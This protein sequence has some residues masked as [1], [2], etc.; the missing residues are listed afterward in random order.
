MAAAA[1]MHVE[2]CPWIRTPRWHAGWDEVLR[3]W[4]WGET[5]TLADNSRQKRPKKS[6][7]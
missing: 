1:G 7:L 3:G 6:H 2:H 4:D 5:K